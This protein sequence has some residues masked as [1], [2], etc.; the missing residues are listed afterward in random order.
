MKAEGA[1]AVICQKELRQ[2]EGKEKEIY[3]K[4]QTAW[5]KDTYMNSRIVLEKNFVDEEIRPEM[6][7]EILYD[8][9]TRFERKPMEELPPKKHANIPV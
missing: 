8:D 7:R 4:K 5:Y 3:L 9:L 1:V 6:T 2:L